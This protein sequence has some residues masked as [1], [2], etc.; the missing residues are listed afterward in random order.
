[1]YSSVSP[2]ILPGT[3]DVFIG[4]QDSVT[5]VFNDPELLPVVFP[6]LMEEVESHILPAPDDSRIVSLDFCK[7]SSAIHHLDPIDYIV[8]REWDAQGRF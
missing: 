3:M 1:M 7:N 2:A 8:L 5:G 6:G 4:I